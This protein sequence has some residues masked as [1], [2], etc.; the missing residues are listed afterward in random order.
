MPARLL[1]IDLLRLSSASPQW[2]SPHWTKI[3]DVAATDIPAGDAVIPKQEHRP[4]M[5]FKT[6]T[7]AISLGANTSAFC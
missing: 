7:M 6:C 5:R 4:T 1:R 2:S 3:P